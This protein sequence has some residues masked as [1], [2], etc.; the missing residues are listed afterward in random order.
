[1]E[2]ADLF[3]YGFTTGGHLRRLLF[4]ELHVALYHALRDLQEGDAQPL[5]IRRGARVLY[6]RPA[7]EALYAEHRTALAAGDDW[8]VIQA[9][10]QLKSP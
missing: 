9:L 6:A 1:M 8:E 3:V 2:Q 7:L 5:G 4:E 10:M